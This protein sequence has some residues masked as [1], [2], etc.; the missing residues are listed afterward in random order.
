MY[1]LQ[2]VKKIAT[3]TICTK[4]DFQS[5]VSPE[6]TENKTTVKNRYITKIQMFT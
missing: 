1:F 4:N 3:E 5:T 6:N 2:L